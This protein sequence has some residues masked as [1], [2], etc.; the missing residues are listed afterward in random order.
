MGAK[1][2]TFDNSNIGTPHDDGCPGADSPGC[3]CGGLSADASPTALDPLN[4]VPA[5]AEATGRM[6]MDPQ[7]LYRDQLQTWRGFNA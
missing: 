4:L 2:L 7:K 1:V 5:F 3:T 6:L